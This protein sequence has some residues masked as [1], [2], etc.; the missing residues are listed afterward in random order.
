MQEEPLNDSNEIIL[1]ASAATDVQKLSSAITHHHT[2][3]PTKNVI[4]RA[5]GAGAINQA[6]KS[7]IASGQFFSQ[8][9]LYILIKPSFKTLEEDAHA[10]I[11]SQN[12]K[13]TTAVEFKIVLEK[14]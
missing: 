10:S 11:G 6:V 14:I 2:K 13:K 7:I 3:T 12:V 1:K 9:G 8:K 5:I 4:V